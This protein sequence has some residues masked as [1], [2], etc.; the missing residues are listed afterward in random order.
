MQSSCRAA[1]IGPRRRSARGRQST[2]RVRPRTRSALPRTRPRACAG[3]TCSSV[4]PTRPEA[5]SRSHCIDVV[6]TRKP[7]VRL[8]IGRDVA[9]CMCRPNDPG[10][11]LQEPAPRPF[12]GTAGPNVRFRLSRG[13]GPLTPTS[14]SASAGSRQPA[15]PCW[16]A[17]RQFSIT[18]IA[19]A[20]DGLRG[21][22]R[23]PLQ[24]RRPMRAPALT[25]R[26]SAAE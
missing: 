20:P 14:Q 19:I 5:R 22:A 13:R 3:W 10:L 8:R 15:S 25:G 4:D 12:A 21:S 16:A 18:L 2:D 26:R 6:C 7:E 9:A 11:Q 24:S 1:R 23:T 17:A